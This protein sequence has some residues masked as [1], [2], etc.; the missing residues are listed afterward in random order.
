MGIGMLP[1]CAVSALEDIGPFDYNI[2]KDSTKYN[3]IYDMF[4][5]NGNASF[6]AAWLRA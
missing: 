3:M 6:P 1:T 5:K 2:A 4:S